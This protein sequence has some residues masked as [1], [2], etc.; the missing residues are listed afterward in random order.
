MSKKKVERKIG[1]IL[2]VIL[3]QSLAADSFLYLFLTQNIMKWQ[4]IRRLSTSKSIQIKTT[5]KHTIL[6]GEIID[7]K[8][9][10]DKRPFW[11]VLTCIHTIPH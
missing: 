2:V 7:E 8:L 11:N 9:L 5:E 6:W 4:W 10:D 1:F 3:Y